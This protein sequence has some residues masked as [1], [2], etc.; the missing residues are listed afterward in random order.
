MRLNFG[1]LRIGKESIHE[2]L[3]LP[4]LDEIG[5]AHHTT[6]VEGAQRHRAD[7]KGF[8]DFA[9][10][11]EPFRGPREHEDRVTRTIDGV[12]GLV[13]VVHEQRGLADREIAQRH[14]IGKPRFGVDDAADRAAFGEF[15]IRAV[16]EMGEGFGGEPRYAKV[17][18]SHDNPEEGAPRSDLCAD[19]LGPRCGRKRRSDATPAAS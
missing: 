3:E 5:V 13:D 10:A 11:V 8:G 4:T 9:D 16:E 14:A 19:V 1:D 17:H 6:R 7:A 2:R 18:G 12:G 15:R